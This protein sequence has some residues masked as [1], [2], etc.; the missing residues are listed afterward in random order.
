MQSEGWVKA[1]DFS[2]EKIS[3]LQ[4]VI[5]DLG[6]GQILWNDLDNEKWI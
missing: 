1:Y 6:I 3:L 5:K 4:N 2:L